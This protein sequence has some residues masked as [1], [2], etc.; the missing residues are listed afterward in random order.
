MS[1][2]NLNSRPLVAIFVW[3]L[4]ITF[5]KWLTRINMPLWLRNEFIHTYVRSVYSLFWKFFNHNLHKWVE[6]CY[7]MAKYFVKV[8]SLLL[9]KKRKLMLL[10]W[11]WSM[12]K[13]NIQAFILSQLWKAIITCIYNKCFFLLFTS[14]YS[15][16][17]RGLE[18][19]IYFLG[20]LSHIKHHIYVRYLAWFEF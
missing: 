4:H 10:L 9:R 3:P 15:H 17:L 13:L 18:Y 12:I 16:S 7:G 19:K 8:G 14:T 1:D 6:M 2:K 5:F 11:K 20:I